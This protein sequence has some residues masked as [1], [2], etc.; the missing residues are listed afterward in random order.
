VNIRDMTPEQR[1]EFCRK[2][3]QAVQRIGTGRRFTTDEAREA[4]KVGGST[5]ALNTEH[6]SRIG[7]I[8][9]RNSRKN[10]PRN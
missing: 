6:M 3:G 9:G 8:G 7:K 5:T 2:G 4:G 10:R 1:R